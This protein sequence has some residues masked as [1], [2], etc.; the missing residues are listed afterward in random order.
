MYLDN[1]RA[2]ERDN[3]NSLR[4]YPFADAAACGNGA[5]VIPPGAIIDAQLY[6]PG[7]ATGRVWLSLVDGDGRLHF[8]DTAGEFAVTAQQVQPLSAIPV[9]FTGDG[10]PLPGGV[11]VCGWEPDVD[12]LLRVGSQAFTVDQTELAP[13]AVTFTGARGVTGFRLDD[14]H[15]VWGDVTIRGANGCDV[16]TYV[17]NGT[18]YLR[19]SAVG[20][21]VTD[22]DVTGFI[23]KI[24]A[25]S[26]NENF[27]VTPLKDGDEPVLPNR[28]V[29]VAPNGANFTGDDDMPYD[30]ED[31]CDSVRKARGTV[32]SGSATVPPN[33]GDVCDRPTPVLRT[34]T[35]KAEGS[36]DRTLSVFDGDPLP[37]LSTLPTRSGYRFSGYYK[38][39]RPYDAE[40][41]YVAADGNQCVATG[42]I[43]R[44]D[45]E[46]HLVVSDITSSAVALFGACD[47]VWRQYSYAQY[48]TQV[49]LGEKSAKIV[50]DWISIL[51]ELT[52]RGR[53]VYVNGSQDPAADLSSATQQ[54]YSELYLFALKRPS[55]APLYYTAVKL[56]A[57]TLS[58]DGVPVLNLVPVRVGNTGHLY[59]TVSG[60][61]LPYETGTGLAPGPDVAPGPGRQYFRADGLGVGRF[62]DGADIT[63]Y[64]HWIPESSS[65][66][67]TFD[68]YGTLHLLAPDTVNYS[69]PL[70]ISGGH[71]VIPNVRTMTSAELS[72]GG[73]D[74]L[75][76]LVLRPAT[77]AGE[78]HLSLRGLNKAF[79]S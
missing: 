53:S 54:P 38:K 16:A 8:S 34:I 59:D 18:K 79:D 13:A 66:T 69:N 60:R 41:A 44:L 29:L 52:I 37:P 6:V 58:R 17:R 43:P 32:P 64:A 63:L 27:T 26:T 2:A 45:D 25:T 55:T 9:T 14:G 47:D 39:T 72:E 5:C 30:Q 49:W 42:V 78:V 1:P 40:V 33:C 56:H 10:G 57:F 50:S 68:G 73:A 22:E 76:D 36:Q 20:Q 67:A 28:C 62:T 65:A 23:T 4:K 48:G 12:A 46:L 75:A 51:R 24:V 11:V 71:G 7:R 77:A 61:I 15:V 3:Q 74:A 70:H 35:L 19:I 31:A 21:A